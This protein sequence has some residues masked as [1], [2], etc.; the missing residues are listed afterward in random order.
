MYTKTNLFFQA[1]TVWCWE[2]RG[3]QCLGEGCMHSYE[4]PDPGLQ[5]GLIIPK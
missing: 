4:M 1:A 5:Q 2:I 3:K